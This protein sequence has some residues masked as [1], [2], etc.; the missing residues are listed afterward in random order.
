MTKYFS[1]TDGTITVFRASE[2]RTYVSAT[3]AGRGGIGFSG[4]PAGRQGTTEYHPATEITKAEYE[5]LNA[6]KMARIKAA[7][8]TLI[9]PGDSWVNN[10]DL[11]PAKGGV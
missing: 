10:T 7:G 3:M 5:A 8:R 1:A 9:N 4:K 11:V 2:T 6:I